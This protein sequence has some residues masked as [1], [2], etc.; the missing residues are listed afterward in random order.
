MYV[1]ANTIHVSFTTWER[2]REDERHMLN[3]LPVFGGRVGRTVVGGGVV[4]KK[5]NLFRVTDKAKTPDYWN[6][7]LVFIWIEQ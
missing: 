2:G 4:S 5:N 6:F 7:I 1:N 3:Y